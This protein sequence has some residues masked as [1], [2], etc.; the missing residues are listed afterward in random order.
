MAKKWKQYGLNNK[1]DYLY[2][3]YTLISNVVSALDRYQ[4][5]YK[6]LDL[7]IYKNVKHDTSIDKYLYNPVDKYTYHSFIE[8]IHDTSM[9]L[10]KY[11][12]DCQDSSISYLMFRK[13]IEKRTHEFG[14]SLI[15]TK[16]KEYLDD[17]RDLRNWIFHNPQSMLNAHKEMHTKGLPKELRETLK[18]EYRFNPIIIDE[19]EYF[20]LENLI[21]LMLHMK[22]RIE[23]F[24]K[25]LVQMTKDFEELYGE[26]ISIEYNYI[27]EPKKYMDYSYSVAQLSMAMQK[28]RYDGSQEEFERITLL[29]KKGGN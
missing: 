26:K 19:Y 20:E 2:V 17:L 11:V 8:K 4:I 5:H 14:L 6:E 27:K 1:E 28:S 16:I 9:S 25:I 21:S 29:N 10:I 23:I 24:N 12:A 13:L 15:D 3:L 7:Y 18:T 22:K